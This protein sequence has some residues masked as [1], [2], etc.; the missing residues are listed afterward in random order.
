MKTLQEMFI[1]NN[2]IR[3]NL[4][5]SN[6]CFSSSR[7]SKGSCINLDPMYFPTYLNISNVYFCLEATAGFVIQLENQ[8]TAI[9]LLK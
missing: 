9:N 3:E 1:N 5:F 6:T 8:K 2:W 4:L 7:K